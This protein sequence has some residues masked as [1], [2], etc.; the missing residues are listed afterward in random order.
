MEIY[1]YEGKSMEEI[2][3][4]ASQQLKVSPDDLIV[5]VTDN[6]SGLF[7]NK[8]IEAEV[9]LV[10]DLISLLKQQIMVIGELMGVD[11]NLE[12]KKRGDCFN[13]VIHSNHNPVLI[14]RGGNTIQAFQRI[15][16]QF[17]VNKMGVY[18]NIIVDVG[19]YKERKIKRLEAMAERMAREVSKTKQEVKLGAMNSYERR[20]IHSLLAED[21]FVYTASVGE[22]PNRYIIIKP[23]EE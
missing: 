9:I 1:K 8:R 13:L 11:I 2:S 15:M 23:K 4:T 12:I 18:I 19:Q 14:G 22:E 7:K 3:A 5:R 16:K 10:P 17:I 20:I 21:Q 6:K